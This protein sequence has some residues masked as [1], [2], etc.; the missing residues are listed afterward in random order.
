MEVTD[1]AKE[2]RL[3]KIAK[4]RQEWLTRVISRD[5]IKEM[6][7]KAVDESNWRVCSEICTDHVMAA[8]WVELEVHN[9][10]NMVEASDESVRQIVEERLREDR[11]LLETE[12]LM[13][14]QAEMKMKRLKEQKTAQ[15]LWMKR[16]MEK[17][18]LR[19]TSD[20]ER[21]GLENYEMEIETLREQ[22][23]KLLEDKADEEVMDYIDEEEEI[24]QVEA[25][26]S[27]EEDDISTDTQNMMDT[28]NNQTPPPSPKDMEVSVP[29]H[30]SQ[31]FEQMPPPQRLRTWRYQTN[32]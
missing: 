25:I 18:I 24:M 15:K 3:T 1:T 9:I 11:E 5:L 12:E 32:K 31:T 19:M 8:A 10:L 26:D 7:E 14:R 28:D 21:L 2:D 27:A 29:T 16:R 17:E 30:V 4:K 13:M 20:M 22:L 6:V 23:G